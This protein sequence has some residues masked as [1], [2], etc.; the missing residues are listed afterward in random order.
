MHN[1]NDL[2]AH[3]P[4]LEFSD[5]KQRLLNTDLIS[6]SA[7]SNHTELASQQWRKSAP[8]NLSA[9]HCKFNGACSFAHA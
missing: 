2:P 8:P 1:G 4:N 5:E 3:T 6:V 7:C 9:S